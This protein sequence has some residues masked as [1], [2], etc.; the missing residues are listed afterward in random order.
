[1]E[2]LLH[3][4]LPGKFKIMGCLSPNCPKRLLNIL[5]IAC[6]SMRDI[7]CISIRPHSYSTSEFHT[8]LFVFRRVAVVVSEDSMNS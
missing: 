4:V 6:I 1:M 5:H 2:V 3:T 7:A 8:A